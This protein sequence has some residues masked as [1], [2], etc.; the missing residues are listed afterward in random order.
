V[1]PHAV[2]RER[3]RKLS[4]ELERRTIRFSARAKQQ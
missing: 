1:T 2:R 4:G 3:M